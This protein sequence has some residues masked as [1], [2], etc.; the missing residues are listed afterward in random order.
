L[1]FSFSSFVLTS[2]KVSAQESAA[3]NTEP[4][5]LKFFQDNWLM[6]ILIPF[7]IVTIARIL[8]EFFKMVAEQKRNKKALRKLDEYNHRRNTYNYETSKTPRASSSR[9]GRVVTSND[10]GYDSTQKNSDPSSYDSGSS[11][12]S[13]D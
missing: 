2:S 3:A 13:W 1:T 6:L 9:I 8:N 10:S 7:F 4:N 12:G 5:V 11:G